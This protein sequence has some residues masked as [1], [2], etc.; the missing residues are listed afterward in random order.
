MLYIPLWYDSNYAKC[1]K[2]ITSYYF[3]FHSGTILIVQTQVEVILWIVFTFHSGTI[4]MQCEMSDSSSHASFTFHSGTI[5][6]VIKYQTKKL[7]KKLYIP[8]WY[9]SNSGVG[10]TSPMG[11]PA[12]HSTLVRF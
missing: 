5:L 2:V 12:L 8:L 11:I 4:L 3:T 7:I 9:D 10:S 6:M 1:A